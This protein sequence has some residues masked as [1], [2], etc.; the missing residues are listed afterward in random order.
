MSD[1][2]PGRWPCPTPTRPTAGRPPLVRHRRRLVRPARLAPARDRLH[3]AGGRVLRRAGRAGD[4]AVHQGGAR[5]ERL[6][7]RPGGHL[8]ERRPPGLHAARRARRRS[9]RRAA[10]AGGRRGG[11]D[12]LRRAGGRRSLLAAARR[13]AHRRP[14]QRRDHAGREQARDGRLSARATRAAD[15][16][17]PGCDP[18]RRAG[19]HHRPAADRR[20]RQLALGAGRCGVLPLLAALAALGAMAPPPAAAARTGGGRR[21]LRE[22]AANRKIALCGPVGAAVRRRPVRAADLSGALPRRRPRVRPVVGV[23][24]A[25]G[26]HRRRVRRPP[27]LG[28]AQRPRVRQQAPPGPDAGHDGRR[29]RAR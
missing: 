26:G 21:A 29:A 10:G 7:A 15:G 14:V 25:V 18:A 22:I 16:D 5:A 19:R 27:G 4:R 20:G 1:F 23:R 28:L 12:V 2:R 6:P 9:R 8:A 24:R 17:P 13:P 3:G 11:D